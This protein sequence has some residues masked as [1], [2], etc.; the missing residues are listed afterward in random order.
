M[1]RVVLAISSISLV[2]S[3][4]SSDKLAAID[5]P[6]AAIG[7]FGVDTA[8]MDPTTKPGDDFYK[9]VNGK[10]T[11]TFQIPADEARYGVLDALRDKSESDV[12]ALL[13]ALSE[14][15]SRPGSVQQKV[16]DF[17]RSWMDVAT[18]EA[19]GIGPLRADLDAIRRA[20]NKSDIVALMGR[21]DYSGPIAFFITADPADPTRYVTNLTQSGLGMPVR[22]YYI[23]PGARFDAYRSEYRIYATKLLELI[24]DENPSASSAAI[25][26]LESK[27]A[28]AHWPRERQREVQ[29]INNP[30]D[31]AGLSKMIPAIEWDSMLAA[32]G[33]GQVQHFVV[34]EISALH[35]GAALLDTQPIDVWKKY[36][37]F[38]VASDYASYLP[39]SFD[40]ASFAFNSKALR[41][42]EVQRDRW[43]R[44][45]ALLD[46]SIG[47]GVG[48]LYVARYFPADYKAKIDALVSNLRT[49]MG[50]RLTRLSWMDDA[51]R[52]EAMKKLATFD[53]RIGY[54]SEWRDYTALT[55]K[56]GTLFENVRSAHRFDWERQVAR[57]GHPVDRKE[58]RM[59]P[60]T[61]NAYYTPLMNQITFPAAILQPPFFDPSADAAVNYG[62]IGSVIGH[63]M[64][65]AFDDQ[66]REFDETGKVRNW[67]T[68]ETNM[69]FL[70][71]TS[72]L[73]AQY[74][75][76]CP[77]PGLC[78][79][80]KLTMG[81]NIGDLGGLEMAYTAYKLSLKGTDA[82]VIGGFT[83]D[84][85]FFMAHTQGWRAVLRE[86]ALRNLVLTNPHSPASARGSIPE[87]NMDAWYA[88]FNVKE[89]D[90]LFI[91]PGDRVHI[92]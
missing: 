46:A 32:A 67:W 78:V 35:D 21:F 81:E 54:P 37:A 42:V 15:P 10:W 88:A 55:V 73:A 2:L 65:H 24:G 90:R 7:S 39:K 26:A 16:M 18:I 50:E 9:Y 59:T 19:R 85:R 22:D 3:A 6:K 75:A 74:N 27:L 44:G 84:Q 60:Q 62:G 57:I 48:E 83:G 11:S 1:K 12:R 89:G 69:R 13:D 47:E 92:W 49:A 23:N 31:R 70:E 56:P 43:K 64:G 87:Q 91:K 34:R 53:P 20:A 52:S 14:T 82:P 66:G 61:V 79:N 72:R 5:A 30:T 38:H 33:L 41:G 71:R 25:I 77:L 17:Y 29:A 80:G 51:T 63:E 40:D 86:D 76:F 45:V 58:W 68:P 8:Q 28:E 36:L 4:Y